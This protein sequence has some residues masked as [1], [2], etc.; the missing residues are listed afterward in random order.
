MGRVPPPWVL[1]PRTEASAIGI[2]KHHAAEEVWRSLDE[3]GDKQSHFLLERF[4]PGSV[5]HVD[6]VVQ[7]GELVF[8]EAHRYTSPPFEVMHGGGLFCSRTLPRE[9]EE[10]RSLTG[11]AREVAAALGLKNGVCHAEFIQGQDG[12]LYFL[13][14]AARVGGAHIADMVEAA[15]GVNL[16]AEW[17]KLEVAAARGE[18]YLPPSPRQ[19]YAG[20]L[21]SLAKQEWPDLSAY[22]EPEIVWR[23]NKRHHAGLI[24][25]AEQPERVRELLDGYMRRFYDDFHT[26]MPAP[27]KATH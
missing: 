8:A 26:S 2:R 16:W 1:K 18:R 15:T 19:D 11:L 24:V 21:I 27:E 25:A 5:R 9:G 7:D 13:E 23:I 14:L 4:V 3:L 10:A 20:V 17:A 22:H 12:R 6:A